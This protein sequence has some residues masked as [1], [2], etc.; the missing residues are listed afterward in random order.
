AERARCADRLRPARVQCPCA[1]RVVLA[2]QLRPRIG[3]H[4]AATRGGQQPAADVMRGADA[5]AERLVEDHVRTVRPLLREANLSFWESATTGSDA[6]IERSARLRSAVKRIHS[7]RERFQQ[8][9]RL[10]ASGELSDPLLRRQL[11]LLE[12][13]FT[14]NQL[15][16]DTIE[17]LSAREA[18]LER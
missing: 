1:G 2:R 17:D 12:H 18:E 11:I 13:A 6:A 15:P 3:S 7:D 10:R 4:R 9:R 8:I 5:E 16:P 14:A